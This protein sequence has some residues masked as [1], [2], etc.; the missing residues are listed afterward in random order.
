VGPVNCSEGVPA[1][2]QLPRLT[3]AQYDATVFDL[4]GLASQPSQLLAPDSVGSV[5]QRAWNGY[6][7]AAEAVSAQVMADPTARA[8]AIPCDP[9]ANE[10]G[11]VKQMI[12]TLGQ[13]T[14]R[15]PLTAAE[16]TRFET[17]YS[18]RAEVT[19][20]G[21]FDQ[22]A[23]LIVRSFLISP[24]FLT[25]A[26]TT[27][28]TPG[29]SAALNGYE[30][31]SRLSFMLWGSMPDDAL[32]AAAAGGALATPAGILEQANRLLA[33]PKA[34]TRVGSF[35]ERYARMGTGTRWAAIQRDPGLYPL[36][37][38]SMVP[39]LS[40]E[41]RR[42]FDFITF[43]QRGTFSDLLT[44]PVA[45]V[46]KAL[47]PIYGLDPAAYGDALTQVNLDPAT[48]SGVFTRAGF[49]TAYA[50]YN[51]PSAI[52]RGAF[53]QKEVLCTELGS[54]PANAES[55]PLPTAGLAT[56]RERTDAQTASGECAGCHHNYINPTGFAMEA[57]DAIGAFQ[58]TEKDTGAQITTVST[59]P[60]GHTLVDVTGPVDLMK[61]I[62]ASPEA[63]ACYAK[64]W[65][66]F[67]YERPLAEEDRCTVENMAAKLTQAD[68]KVI[69]LVADL[70]QSQSFR[71][72]ATEVT[73]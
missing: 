31:A 47:A 18:K 49:L 25:R 9:V 20:A 63:K 29:T 39:V 4:F 1:T 32:L 41:T 64:H 8:K 35:H 68:Y 23:E 13:R 40:D 17:I 14:F 38:E 67:A 73:Q 53:L 24:S 45:F 55:T 59:V 50:L 43:E 10:A 2:S 27:P 56:N 69:N 51:R 65:V 70:T 54:P 11:C 48:R 3:G 22:V 66:E 30:V 26:E 7:A 28:A 44:T 60:V 62:A 57:Y 16:V 58:T 46:N 71:N 5:D 6:K 33:D 15:R 72:R 34:R 19:E 36:F 52:L 21:T 61:A 42:I 37:A 12:E